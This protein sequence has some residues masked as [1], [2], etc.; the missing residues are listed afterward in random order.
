ML[1]VV[2]LVIVLSPRQAPGES[3]VVPANAEPLYSNYYPGLVVFCITICVGAIGGIIGVA[4][5]ELT[6]PR[7][8]RAIE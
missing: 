7:Y 3:S 8:A 1:I 6:T 5:V 4:S 2:V